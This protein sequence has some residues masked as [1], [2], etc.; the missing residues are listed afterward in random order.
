MSQARFLENFDMKTN[1][2]TFF[3]LALLVGVAAPAYAVS[4]TDECVRAGVAQNMDY[5]CVGTPTGCPS[6][7]TADGN[8]ET[9]GGTAT[10]CCL[11]PKNPGCTAMV[12]A[13]ASAPKQAAAAPDT[14]SS[15]VIEDP[16]EKIGLI[17]VLN[18]VILA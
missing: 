8:C 11:C 15:I 4:N 17:G 13:A 10:V 6:G 9:V 16:L 14:G 1:I 18:R 2:I 5:A 3:S 12:Q 7:T